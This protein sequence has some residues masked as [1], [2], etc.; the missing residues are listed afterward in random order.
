MYVI[1]VLQ[2]EQCMQTDMLNVYACADLPR[3]PFDVPRVGSRGG[4]GLARP[5]AGGEW[6]GVGVRVARPGL[7][8]ARL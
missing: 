7:A 8:D 5:A 2:Q 4:A 1:L 6:A 3:G